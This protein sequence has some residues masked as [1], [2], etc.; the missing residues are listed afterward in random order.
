MNLVNIILGLFHVKTLLAVDPLHS[1]LA[2]DWLYCVDISVLMLTSHNKQ[3]RTC[4]Y[5]E[6]YSDLQ[7]GPSKI[8]HSLQEYKELYNMLSHP[9]FVALCLMCFNAHLLAMAHQLMLFIY[10]LTLICWILIIIFGQSYPGITNCWYLPPEHQFI[11]SAFSDIMQHDNACEH[12]RCNMSWPMCLLFFQK[13]PQQIMQSTVK[14]LTL[15]VTMQLIWYGG[16]LPKTVQE[17]QVYQD[18]ILKTVTFVTM[19]LSQDAI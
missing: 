19:Y 2:I 4:N 16:R 13:S 3:L 6:F 7:D 11:G 10:L 9:F 12:Q 8:Q 15:R 1:P 17:I 5:P 14:A 18:L